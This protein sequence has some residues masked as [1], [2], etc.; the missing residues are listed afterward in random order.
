MKRADIDDAA[1]LALVG[2]AVD[3]A[4]LMV[5]RGIPYKLA[6]AKLEH[7]SDRGL[8]DYGVVLNRPW[9]TDA[10]RALLAE[11]TP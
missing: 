6:L 9:L 1:V 11:A 10:G 7:L 3:V 4:E 8:I 5:E 2:N